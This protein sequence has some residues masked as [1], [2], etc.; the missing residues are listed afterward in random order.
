MEDS[1]GENYNLLACHYPRFILEDKNAFEGRGV[2]R[3]ARIG[4]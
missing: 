3:M 4:D 1:S 2:S